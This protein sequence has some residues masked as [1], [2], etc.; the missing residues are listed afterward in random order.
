VLHP[1]LIFRTGFVAASPQGSQRAEIAQY[2]QY[3]NDEAPD[4]SFWT[5]YDYFILEREA[6]AARRALILSIVVNWGRRL[7]GA[8]R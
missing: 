2:P 1:P 6:R 5:P 4:P 8:L 3:R 7:R